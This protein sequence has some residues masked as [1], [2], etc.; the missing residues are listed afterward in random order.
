MKPNERKRPNAVVGGGCLRY[1]GANGRPNNADISRRHYTA[2]GRIALSIDSERAEDLMAS[3]LMV[4]L[5]L[6]KPLT[7]QM[8]ASTDGRYTRARTDLCIEDDE[9]ETIQVY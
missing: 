2:H 5:A 1:Y 4:V 7:E 8:L 9:D 3:T 6:L